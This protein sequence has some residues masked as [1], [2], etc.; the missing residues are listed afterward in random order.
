MADTPGYPDTN[1]RMFIDREGRL[2]LLGPTILANRWETALMKY[3]ISSDYRHDGPPRLEISEVMHLTPGPEFATAISNYVRKV[4]AGPAALA[5]AEE[6]R[7][8]VSGYLQHLRAQ[9]GDKLS[10]GSVHN[11]DSAAGKKARRK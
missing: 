2:W 10:R 7:D 6:M 4:E 3:N 11:Y 8:G 9:A 1:C 5:I